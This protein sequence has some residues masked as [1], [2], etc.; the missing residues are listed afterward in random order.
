MISSTKTNR[1]VNVGASMCEAIY[2]IFADKLS[3]NYF[4]IYS[5][6]SAGMR[7]RQNVN[8]MYLVKL[9]TFLF[10]SFV[11]GMK[12]RKAEDIAYLDSDA[13]VDC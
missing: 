3:D 1:F 11:S 7:V 9:F 8:V 6:C 4:G 13:V 12:T 2:E 5:N 10:T